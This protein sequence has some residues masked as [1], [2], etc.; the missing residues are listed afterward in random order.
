[1][2]EDVLDKA[3]GIK[4]DADGNVLVENK[5]GDLKPGDEGYVEPK[6]DPPGDKDP[7]GD[8]DE[9]ITID[10][11][12]FA[13]GRFTSLDEIT[14]AIS[15]HDELTE[16][17]T[18]SEKSKGELEENLMTIKAR[19]EEVQN[20]NPLAKFPLFYKLAKY[21]EANPDNG[22][23]LQQLALGTPDSLT[24]LKT[25]FMLEHPEFKDKPEDV[26]FLIKNKYKDYLGKEA[27]SESDEYRSAKIS[28]DAD[29]SSAKSRLLKNLDSI[30]IPK[31]PT[32]E[33]V[34]ANRETYIKSWA[35]SF[36]EIVSEID[37]IVVTLPDSE[38]KTKTVELANIKLSNEAKSKYVNY[39]A[40]LIG[41]GNYEPNEAS[42]KM[43]KAEVRKQYI[44]DNLDAIVENVY[45]NAHLEGKQGHRIRVTN[46]TQ[47][48]KG[49]KKPVEKDGVDLGKKLVED[50]RKGNF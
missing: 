38:D 29:A 7:P 8:S 26:D 13:E 21:T 45:N 41:G 11:K 28:L 23:F 32:E 47:L 25:D 20:N 43:I 48:K 36:K 15:S 30:E 39:A 4:R 17:F 50:S 19:L 46:T 16:K 49:Y 44:A 40:S 27:D 14:Q 1:M 35:P 2:S 3:F 9:P 31:L 34:K 5:E 22:K 37:S 6:P 33:E 42:A 12:D 24:V 10:F 18:N